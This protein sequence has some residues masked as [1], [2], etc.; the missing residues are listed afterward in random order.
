MMA[1]EEFPETLKPVQMYLVDLLEL[2]GAKGQAQFYR[3]NGKI[4]AIVTLPS[5]PTNREQASA[6]LRRGFCQSFDYETGCKVP[7]WFAGYTD[8]E[9]LRL[10]GHPASVRIGR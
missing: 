5:R 10:T 2:A 9:I 6:M 8:Q 1:N 7:Q 3:D 4:D